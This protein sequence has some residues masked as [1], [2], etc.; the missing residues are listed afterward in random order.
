MP[1]RL[2]RVQKVMPFGPTLRA[3]ADFFTTTFFVPV[4]DFFAIP[5]F[6]MLGQARS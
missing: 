3:G 5:G 2:A 4:S 6:S 1:S